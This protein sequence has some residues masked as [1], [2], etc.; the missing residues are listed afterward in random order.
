MFVSIANDLGF[1]AS[2][3]FILFLELDRPARGPAVF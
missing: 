3:N 2:T 1:L